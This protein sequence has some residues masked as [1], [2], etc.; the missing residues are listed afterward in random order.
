MLINVERI[1]QSVND[2][3]HAKR[4]FAQ[5]TEE[6]KGYNLPLRL[7]NVKE[8]KDLYNNSFALLKMCFY[9]IVTREKEYEK[10]IKEFTLAICSAPAWVS[11]G[12]RNGWKSD[13]LT[14]DLG[15]NLS[16]S[17][18]LTK[19]LFTSEEQSLIKKSIMQKGFEP[20][21]DEWV[22][23]DTRIHCLDTMGHNWWSVCV[24]GLG[25]IVVTMDEDT[26]NKYKYLSEIVDCIKQWLTYKGDRHLNKHANFGP[27]VIILNM[28]AI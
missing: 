15:F 12:K 6:I 11:Q 22:N 13:L 3:P 26:P 2:N 21:Y 17:F 24:C 10:Y 19:N 9:Y 28:W 8:H 4:Y 23:P 5:I 1:I 20:L 18:Y 16:L 25:G 14:G 27:E 7:Q